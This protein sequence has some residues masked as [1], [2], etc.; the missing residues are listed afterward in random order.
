MRQNAVGLMMV[1]IIH[2]DER[3]Q[4]AGVRKGKIRQASE[5]RLFAH[6]FPALCFSTIYSVNLWPQFCEYASVEP[7]I[8]PIRPANKS[9]AEPS[10]AALTVSLSFSEPKNSARRSEANCSGVIPCF[11]ASSKI[12]FSS[13][14]VIVIVIASLLGRA[15]F[16]HVTMSSSERCRF[17]V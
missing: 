3:Y 6:R 4:R 2:V 14:G 1:R 8:L 16:G 5:F 7:L 12:A 15:L 9:A 11:W 17:H 10:E 13:F